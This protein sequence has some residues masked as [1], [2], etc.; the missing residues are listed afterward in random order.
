VYNAGIARQIIKHAGLS[1]KIRVLDGVLKDV[2]PVV[3]S[4]HS[5]LDFVFIDHVKHMYVPDLKLL[6]ATPG[7]LHPGTVVA[8]DNMYT[9]GWVGRQA[10]INQLLQE[11]QLLCKQP[12]T[13]DVP[14]PLVCAGHQLTGCSCSMCPALL[15]KH[16]FIPAIHILQSARVPGVHE[17]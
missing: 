12:S 8:A 15:L 7:L 9:P 6:M 17:E 4:E 2:L 13:S 1:H 10:H 16:C 11:H 3:Q 5:P 14:L